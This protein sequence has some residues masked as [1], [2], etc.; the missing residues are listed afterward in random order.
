MADVE[1]LGNPTA[2]AYLRA[3]LLTG[4]R[5]EE[6]AAL[7]WTDVNVRWRKLTL[8][9]KVETTRVIPLSPYL[10][11]VLATLPRRN[12]YV[13]AGAGKTGHIVDPR[14]SHQKALQSAAIEG[15][16]VHGLRRS[17][18]LLGEAAGAPAGAIAQ[19]MGHWPWGP[20]KG[21]GRAA[22]M[23]CGPFS[24]KIEAHVLALAGVVFDTEAEPGKLR[25]VKGAPA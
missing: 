25:V 3:L 4:A 16:T 13:F 2:S 18:S 19:I 24:V 14:A 5:R 20:P 12:Q 8:A 6:M 11:Q 17:F 15:L 9:D 10:A 22:S 7:K 1:E 21:T 23:P